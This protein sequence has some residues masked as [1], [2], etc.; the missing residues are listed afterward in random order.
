MRTRGGGW[1][2]ADGD[3]VPALQQ[4]WLDAIAVDLPAGVVA[5]QRGGRFVTAFWDERGGEGG[6]DAVAA[7]LRRLPELPVA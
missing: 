2:D 7:V 3:P 1:Q 5:L 4:Q 6:V